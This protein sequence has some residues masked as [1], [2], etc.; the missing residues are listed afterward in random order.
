MFGTI[1]ET[2]V[3]RRL[4]GVWIVKE[5][6]KKYADLLR[7]ALHSGK[8]DRVLAKK[9]NRFTWFYFIPKK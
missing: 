3:L 6:N 5:S 1:F 7:R 2:I 8:I 4:V 9:G